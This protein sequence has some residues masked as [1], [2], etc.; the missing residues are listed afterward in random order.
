[1][2][3]TAIVIV[4]LVVLA[5]IFLVLAIALGI[6][7]KRRSVQPIPTLPTA[8]PALDTLPDLS[9]QPCCVVNGQVLDQTYFAQLDVVV[10]T[11]P[12]PARDA[13]AGFPSDSLES[14]ACFASVLPTE[15]NTAASP[16]ARKGA[17]LYYALSATD[18]QCLMTANCAIIP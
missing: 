17:K 4:S 18:S 16:V 13:C 1:M 12:T 11:I 10:S 6:I 7:V 8:P 14:Q 9:D 3:T 5:F 15:P 2:G